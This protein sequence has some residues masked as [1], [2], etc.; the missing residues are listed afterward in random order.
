MSEQRYYG[1]KEEKEHEKEEKEYEKQGGASGEK[2]WEEKWRTDPV[3]AAGWA[4]I[5][6]WVGVALLLENLGT[7]RQLGLPGDAWPMILLGAGIIVLGQVVVRLTVAEYRRPITGSLII[8]LLLV[9]AGLGELVNV[10]IT[11][12]LILIA[13]G[14]I[15]LFSGIFRRR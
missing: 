1:E 4:A 9:A 12:P 7:W 14:L 11:G 15:L 6:I 5:L 2:D 3:R 10:D 8:G 13:I